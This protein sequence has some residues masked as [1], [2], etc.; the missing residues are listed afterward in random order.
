MMQRA[1]RFPTVGTVLLGSLGLP[2]RTMAQSGLAIEVSAQASC[3]VATFTLGL[4]GGTGSAD[5]TWDF[6]DGETLLEP[7]VAAF[8]HPVEHPYPGAGAFDWS[9]LAVD[10][11]DPALTGTAMGTLSIGPSVTLTSDIF[12]PVLTLE[13]GQAVVQF[14]AEVSG[15]G[16]PTAGCAEGGER[17]T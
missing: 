12:P 9:A 2:R 3:E 7:A 1:V 15:G 10:L 11:G 5:L 8:P 6:G 14:T 4:T 17:G 16:A 13:S